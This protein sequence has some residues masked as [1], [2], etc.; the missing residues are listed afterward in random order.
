MTAA[1]PASVSLRRWLRRQLAEPGPFRERLEAAVEHDDPVEVKRLLEGLP[2][3]DGQRRYV[4]GLLEAW[5]R[6]AAAR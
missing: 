4:E 5:E 2:F 3:S 6:E 1:S